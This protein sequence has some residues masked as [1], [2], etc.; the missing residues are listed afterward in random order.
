MSTEELNKKIEEL[1]LILDEM[2]A[3]ENTFNCFIFVKDERA[4]WNW[5]CDRGIELFQSM[6]N[7]EEEV[8]G[9]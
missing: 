2:D 3:R 5:L 9:K 6:K 7:K 4:T 1:S 8:G